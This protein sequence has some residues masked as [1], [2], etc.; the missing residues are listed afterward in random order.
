MPSTPPPAAQPL[1]SV[2]CLACR[3][4]DCA[5]GGACPIEVGRIGSPWL[6]GEEERIYET[7]RDVSAESEPKLCRIAELVHFAVD[8]GYRRVGVAFCSEMF[9]EVETLVRVLRRY[10]DVVPVCCRVSTAD[11]DCN[12]VAQARLLEAAGTELNVIAGLCLGCDVLF[13]R[14][15]HAPVTTLF[16]KDRLLA[17]NPVGAIYTRYHL[18]DLR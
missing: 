13:T 4:R 18:E 16:V 1:P 3:G 12:P 17:H 7:G 10:F 11:A 14:R 5:R 9:D 15:S 2:D 8:A 6:R